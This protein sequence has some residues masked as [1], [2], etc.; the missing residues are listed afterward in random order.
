[1]LPYLVQKS[2][3]FIMIAQHIKYL[4]EFRKKDYNNAAIRWVLGLPG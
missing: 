3:T 4:D 1:M 2:K